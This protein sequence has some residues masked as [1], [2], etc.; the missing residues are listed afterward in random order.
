MILVSAPRETELRPLGKQQEM[1][2]ESLFNGR[3]H[4]KYS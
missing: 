1:H 4:T 2:K 3:E